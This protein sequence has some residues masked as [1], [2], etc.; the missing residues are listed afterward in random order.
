MVPKVAEV[1]GFQGAFPVGAG[2]FAGTIGAGTLTGNVQ[3]G[4]FPRGEQASG[5]ETG[6]LCVCL[7]IHQLTRKA[8]VA[9]I[10]LRKIGEVADGRRNGT[11]A[12]ARA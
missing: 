10:Q 1:S 8:I 11:C 7:G 4:N 9:Q 2:T 12:R 3:G 6:N 5:W